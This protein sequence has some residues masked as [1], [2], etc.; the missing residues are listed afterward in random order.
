MDREKARE[1]DIFT[2][3]HN[4][5]PLPRHV[6]TPIPP[7]AVHNLALEILQP[8][9][10]RIPGLIQLPYRRD[11][12]IALNRIPFG[13][14]LCILAP[15]DLHLNPPL[16]L[17]II[18]GRRL[19]C[20]VEPNVLVELVLIRYVPQILLKYEQKKLVKSFLDKQLM[21]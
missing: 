20:S 7:R 4:P 8:G 10:I 11:E 5:D 18:P 12:E 3:P 13:V 14:I 19:D 9:D 6:V 15:S 1:G 21:V 16:L 2:I 17:L